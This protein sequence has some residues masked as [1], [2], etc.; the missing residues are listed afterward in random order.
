M[1]FSKV[2]GDAKKREPRFFTKIFMQEKNRKEKRIG[3]KLLQTS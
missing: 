3:K 2:E 1:K